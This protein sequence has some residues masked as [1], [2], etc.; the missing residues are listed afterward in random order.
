MKDILKLIIAGAALIGIAKNWDKLEG[1]FEKAV[2][3]GKGKF[4]KSCTTTAPQAEAPK[5][6]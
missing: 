1:K 4:K 5:A 6:E 2:E 3:A